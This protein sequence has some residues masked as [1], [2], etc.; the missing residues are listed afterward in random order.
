MQIPA[1]KQLFLAGCDIRD[2]FYAVRVEDK[3]SDYFC[4]MQDV[5]G[6]ELYRTSNGLLGESV[7]V[8]FILLLSVFYQW[9]S[10]G[11]FSWFKLF[12]SRQFA[13]LCHFQGIH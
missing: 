11:A 1:E 10:V 3:L 4:L 5:T 8:M 2:C 7:A 6:D 9:G 13:E 12:M